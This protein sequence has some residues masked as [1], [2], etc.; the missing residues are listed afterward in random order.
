MG[1]ID[2]IERITI[3]SRSVV[4][5]LKKAPEKEAIVSLLQVCQELDLYYQ[6]YCRDDELEYYRDKKNTY[7]LGLNMEFYIEGSQWHEVSIALRKLGWS[8][9]DVKD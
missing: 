8:A 6:E 5:D 3:L 1:I 9:L 2:E 4:T 7:E